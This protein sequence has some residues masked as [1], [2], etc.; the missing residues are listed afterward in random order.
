MPK[1]IDEYGDE[2]DQIVLRRRIEDQLDRRTF[3]KVFDADT[4]DTIQSLAQKGFFDVLEHV[5]STGKEAHV[6]VARDTNDN[7][8][9]VKIYKRATSRFKRMGE[10]IAGDRR[11]EGIGHNRRDIVNAWCRKEFKNLLIANRAR[12]SVPLVLGFRQN[13]LVM[14]FIGEKQEA[15]PRLKD[16]KPNQKDL[17]GL[18]GQVVDFM[19]GLYIA[20]LVHSDLSEYNIL[21]HNGKL[22]VIDMG[23]AM[24]VKHPKAKEFFER[25]VRN[26]ANYFTKAGLETTYDEFYAMVKAKKQ[27]IE[28]HK[29][30]DGQ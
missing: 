4:L 17:G 14:E 29:E 3:Q 5:V 11:F 10:Y 19:A 23:Q 9:A 8:R 21:V 26:M 16:T 1:K 24:L 22:I 28:R 25:D 13:V 7:K 15:A 6:F 30:K 20:G 2:F 18:R 12:L 27:V